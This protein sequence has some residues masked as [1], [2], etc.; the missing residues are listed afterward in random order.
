MGRKSSCETY[1]KL[2]YFKIVGEAAN[3]LD[4]IARYVRA[5]LAARQGFVLDIRA[6][7]TCPRADK[8]F[9]H[10]LKYPP[11]CLR[12][13][14]VVGLSE[15]RTFC[16]LYET[17]V[18]T[19]GY[20]ARCFCDVEMANQWVL[21]DDAPVQGSSRR[22]GWLSHTLAIVRHSLNPMRLLHA[23]TSR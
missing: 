20:R 14:A 8:V 12:K 7:T 9:I 5:K 19:R 15:N 11:G 4:G 16:S 13:I 22:L 21:N 3:H 18:R 1:E 6:V 10:V 17:L 2:T 23:T